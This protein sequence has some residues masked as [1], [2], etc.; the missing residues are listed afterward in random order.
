MNGVVFHGCH[1]V[2]VQSLSLS[3]FIH[4][5]PSHDVILCPVEFPRF[6]R[7]FDWKLGS[8]CADKIGSRKQSNS[9]PKKG[10]VKT[11]GNKR[12]RRIQWVFLKSLWVAIF[13]VAE[14]ENLAKHTPKYLLSQYPSFWMGRLLE[15]FVGFKLVV[16]KT[17]AFFGWSD[18]N[19]IDVRSPQ[20]LFEVW[21]LLTAGSGGSGL[22]LMWVFVR[23]CHK[24]IEMFSGCFT[25]TVKD[26]EIFSYEYLTWKH[27]TWQVETWL[28]LVEATRATWPFNC[29]ANHMGVI[30]GGA[31]FLCN[32]KFWD[33]TT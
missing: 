31:D 11:P 1:G 4:A 13:K 24:K 10:V 14:W 6:D 28:Q 19:Q 9:T 7:R 20:A 22:L 30:V 17:A 27:Q 15:V 23:M 21:Q 32:W 3:I 18:S 26:D 5:K 12:S 29:E 2:I 33:W 16:F 8:N 25:V